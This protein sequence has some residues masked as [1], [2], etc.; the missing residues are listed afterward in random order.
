MPYMYA[1]Y[2]NALHGRLRQ[3]GALHPAPLYVCLICECLICM[4]YMYALYVC[5]I[6]MPGGLRPAPESECLIC[7]PYM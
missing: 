7:M 2:V 4:P 3:D 1:L 5:L 6:C